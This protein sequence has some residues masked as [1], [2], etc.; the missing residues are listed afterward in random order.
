MLYPAEGRAGFLDAVYLHGPGGM[1]AN[2]EAASV[3]KGFE[4]EA[5]I[6]SRLGE[7]EYELRMATFRLL[8]YS[9]KGVRFVVDRAGG[10][11]GVAYFPHLRP[12]VHPGARH[13]VD[14]SRLRKGP[15]ARPG[16][17]APLGGLEVGVS[18]VK[19]SP[20]EVEWLAPK[21]REGYQPHD[22]L[23][24]RTIVLRQSGRT[25]AFVG[26]DLFGMQRADILPMRERAAA[27]GV[28]DMVLAMSHDH[29]APDTIG[30]YGHYPEKY[31]A[32]IQDQVVRGVL[33]AARR[34]RPVRE[35]R[36]A[37]RE[38]PMNGARVAGYFRNARNPGLLDPTL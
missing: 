18:E 21:V 5:A 26:A 28:Q 35:L 15:E 31:I 30:V 24:A 4:N 11:I 23:W 8:D 27:G 9:A 16:G 13:L 33:E 10:T 3:P 38:L 36:A 22:D 25:I 12:R 2:A 29:A 17:A 7:P 6:R 14:L 32:Y 34:L 1:F 37:A 20:L 19:L